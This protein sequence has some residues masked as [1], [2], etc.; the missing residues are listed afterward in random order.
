MKPNSALAIFLFALVGCSSPDGPGGAADPVDPAKVDRT[1]PAAV[2]RAVLTAYKAKDLATVAEF[3]DVRQQKLLRD[4]AA[5]GDKHPSYAKIFSTYPWP[6][7]EKWQGDV[8]EVRYT[9]ADEAYVVMGEP[10]PEDLQ[11]LVLKKVDGKWC[12]ADIQTPEAKDFKA[13]PSAPPG[14]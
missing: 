12:Y 2:A 4:V 6:V 3:C 5:Q 1:D 8:G 7:I 13:L 11:T 10:S 14:T 9:T